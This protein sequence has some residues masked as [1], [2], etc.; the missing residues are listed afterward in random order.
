MDAMLQRLI[1]KAAIHDVLMRYA[2]GIDR[3]DFD[4]VASCFTPDAYADYDRLGP[5]NGIDQILGIVKGVLRYNHTTHFMANQ[6]IE[7]YGDTA[8]METYAI[9]YL[10]LEKDGVEYDT[11][12]GLRYVDKLVKRDDKWLINHRVHRAHWRRNDPVLPVP[13]DLRPGR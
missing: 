9:A 8:V 10:R 4:L 2:K 1:D 3:R 13:G 5:V 12:G 11:T 7:V 6:L